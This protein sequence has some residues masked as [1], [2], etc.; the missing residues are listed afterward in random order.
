[1]GLMEFEW[2]PPVHEDQVF[3]P[4]PTNVYTYVR[5]FYDDFAL[6]GVA[7]LSWLFGLTCGV[8]FVWTINS[9]SIFKLTT[10]AVLTTSIALSFAYFL[11]TIGKRYLLLIG[12]SAICSFL[13]ERYA[14]ARGEFEVV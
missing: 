8:F 4:I 10:S 9:P 6:P 2:T 7:A 1:M 5:T 11:P 3:V 12:I 14:R 13:L